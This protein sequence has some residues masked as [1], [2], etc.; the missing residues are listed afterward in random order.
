MPKFVNDSA[1]ITIYVGSGDTVAGAVWTELPEGTEFTLGNA[2]A[3]EVDVT[4]FSSPNK[5][6][7]TINGFIAIGDGTL[8]F[9][10]IIGD[11]NQE[12]IRA[13]VG[14]NPIPM[15]FEQSDG[16]K[17]RTRD[18]LVLIRSIDDGATLGDA[19]AISCTIRRTGE[20]TE[21]TTDVV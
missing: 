21:T 15:R 10:D 20:V 1:A 6:R 9:F 18:T 13:A 19:A 8:T 2:E 11:V 3:E 16:E 12:R 14:G 5:E 7:E 17:I 4:S